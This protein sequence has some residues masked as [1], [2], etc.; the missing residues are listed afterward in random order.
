M[1]ERLPAHFL[2]LVA[3]AL[4]NS[5]WRKRSLRTFLRRMRIRESFLAT[6]NEDETKRDF[7]YRLFPALEA[8]DVG[9]QTIRRM[10]RE[11]SEQATFPDLGNWEDAEQMK[12]AALKSVTALKSYLAQQE[13]SLH[14]EREEAAARKRAQE[15][16]EERTRQRGDLAKLKDRLDH[17]ALDLGS[18]AAGYA[19][20]EWFFDLIQYCEVT[21]RRPYVVDGRQIDGSVS[22][23]GTTYLVELKFTTDQA[24]AT[25]VDIF[26]KKV[27]D[28]ADN[29]MG[30][31]V[32][33]AGYSEVAIRGA[34]VPRT[35]LLL[36]D[37]GHLY[38]MLAGTLTF[39]EV[40]QRVRRH[41]SQ[42]S[43]AYLAAGE[44]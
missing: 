9:Q 6:W 8:T 25:D 13:V 17:L 14:S 22:I 1:A 30:I 35:P 2:D 12:M 16:R 4:L 20:Q 33:I 44:M 21:H 29:T 11:L 42:T 19:F 38:A 36:L 7:I 23:A 31:M 37:Y 40:V 39:D 3:D 24:A 43:R 5:F 10:A 26:F 28:K 32:S 27:T 34:S 41:C 18:Q 15:V